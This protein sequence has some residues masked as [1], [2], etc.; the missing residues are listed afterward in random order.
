LPRG[1]RVGRGSPPKRTGLTVVC[2]GISKKAVF[3]GYVQ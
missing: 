1:G 3:V 2:R